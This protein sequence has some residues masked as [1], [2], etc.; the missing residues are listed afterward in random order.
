ML[1]IDVC[2]GDSFYTYIRH[3]N[4]YDVEGRPQAF[5]ALTVSFRKAFC[6]NVYKLYQLFDAVYNQICLGSI[7]KQ[8]GNG[9]TYLVA[10][11]TTARSGANATV[12][13]IQVAFAQKLAELIVP[14]LQTLSWGDTFNRAKK[15]I[16]LFE[17]DSPLFFDYLKK[18]SVIVSPN[19]QP[20]A[21][22]YDAI[23]AELKQMT[24]QKKALSSS[25]EQLQSDLAT[26][27]QENKSLKSQLHASSSSTEKKYRS[28][29]DQFQAELAQVT[30][31][32]DSL[33]QKIQEATSSIELID[34]PFQ[35]LTR[36]LAGRF[37]ESRSPKRIEYLEEKHEAN[38]KAQK[39]IWRDWINSILLGL[40]LVCCCA[41]LLIVLRSNSAESTTSDNTN[42]TAQTATADENN[43]IIQE[44]LTNDDAV[45]GDGNN[46]KY[47]DWND[48]TINVLHSQ[49]G[50]V[51]KNT[52]YSVKVCLKDWNDA[53]V[54]PGTWLVDLGDNQPINVD[55][56]DSF[57]VPEDLSP[58]TNLLIKYMYNNTPVITRTVKV[59]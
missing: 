18:Y 51:K 38:K 34:Q 45:L 42:N 32:R 22:A 50:I 41:I 1:Q 40:V 48:C 23:A 37:P 11:L 6:T 14:T 58:G 8:S 46:P 53:T 31:E 49:H 19:M 59:E 47:S 4:V 57:V 10:D 28:K 9:E 17:V 25:N 27:S 55:G 52:K 54:P 5:F 29:L 56:Q 24:A 26:L 12:D 2:A 39:P 43:P 21:I 44:E 30:S 36:L 35:K 13:K 16:S 33:K 7:L 15:S 20:A 3:Q